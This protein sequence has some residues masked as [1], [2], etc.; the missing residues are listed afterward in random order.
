VIFR[1][2][3]EELGAAMPNL[4]VVHVLQEPPGDWI[5]EAGL[6]DAEI[7]SRHVPAAQYRRFQFFVCGAPAMLDA[8]EKLLLSIGVPSSRLNTE[9]FDFV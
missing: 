9:R 4:L 5:G 7:I 6:I 2:E 8:M 1:D 3:L